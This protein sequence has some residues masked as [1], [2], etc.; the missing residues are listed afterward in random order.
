MPAKKIEKVKSSLEFWK[1]C[2][3]G[4]RP[5]EE[6][7]VIVTHQGNLQDQLYEVNFNTLITKIDVIQINS[8]PASLSF[9]PGFHQ[10]FNI[11]QKNKGNNGQQPYKQQKEALHP[12]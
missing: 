6:K 5:V 3:S 1:N 9:K 10:N 2:K 8:V 12:S 11:E 7:G 4:F